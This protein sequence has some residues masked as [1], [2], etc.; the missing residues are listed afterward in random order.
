MSLH[1]FFI[2]N[3]DL[4]EINIP[5]DIQ[6]ELTY[7]DLVYIAIKISLDEEINLSIEYSNHIETIF[8]GSEYIKISTKSKFK[9]PTI[10]ILLYLMFN[11]CKYAIGF[12]INHHIDNIK[13]HIIEFDKDEIKNINNIIQEYSLDCTILSTILQYYCHDSNHDWNLKYKVPKSKEWQD[14]IEEFTNIKQ[15]KSARKV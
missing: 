9:N 7:I 10:T 1:R 5:W 2:D 15:V 8:N 11:Y 6:D 3:L 4:E 14:F 12:T 13:D